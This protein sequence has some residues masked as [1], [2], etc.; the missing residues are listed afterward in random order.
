[1]TSVVEHPLSDQSGI[2][3]AWNLDWDKAYA[4]GFE[5][6]FEMG[7]QETY[8]KII[9]NLFDMHQPVDFIARAVGKTP[10]YVES[11]IEQAAVKGDCH[12]IKVRNP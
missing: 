1:M 8:R 10:E 3:E 9:M 2:S 7:Q 6:G 5:R 12:G 4:I 11:V